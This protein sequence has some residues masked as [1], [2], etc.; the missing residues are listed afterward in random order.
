MSITCKHCQRT[1]ELVDG[2]WV[3]P[4]ATGD[5]SI[6]RETCDGNDEDRSATHKPSSDE[7]LSKFVI[8]VDGE[9]MDHA[10]TMSEAKRHRDTI[11][12]GGIG[13]PENTT[14]EPRK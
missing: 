2:T 5:D 1:I 14:I 7:P 8:K 4:N 11:I 6:W 10:D 9:E 13:T 3:D 12:Y